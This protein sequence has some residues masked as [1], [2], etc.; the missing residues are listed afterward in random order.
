MN[1]DLA[2]TDRMSVAATVAPEDLSCG[3][4]VAVLNEVVEFPS[5]RWFDL[6]SQHPPEEPIRVR[7]MTLDSGTPLKVQAICLP[8]VFVRHADGY[9]NR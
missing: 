1:A 8:F 2:E 6:P 7:M 4:Y 3:D 9:S 5:C